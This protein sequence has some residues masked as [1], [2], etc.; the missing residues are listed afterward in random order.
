[1][2]FI[3]N[4]KLCLWH[5]NVKDMVNN[6]LLE[7]DN[8]YNEVPDFYLPEYEN[9]I[10]KSLDKYIGPDTQKSAMGIFRAFLKILVKNKYEMWD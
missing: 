4:D 3:G 9:D 5:D 2:K 7:F 6:L 1:V 8:V 10:K